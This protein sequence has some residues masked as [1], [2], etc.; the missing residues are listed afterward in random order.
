VPEPHPHPQ[1][2]PHPSVAV[3]ARAG[4]PALLYVLAAFGVVLGGWGSMVSVGTGLGLLQPRDSYVQSVKRARIE[5]YERF[6]GRFGSLLPAKEDMERYAERE[7]DANYGR[8][9]AALPLAAVGAILSCLLFAGC[10]RT[11]MGDP[12]GLSAWSLAAMV[13]LPYQLLAATLALVTAHDLAG[14]LP[15]PSP[16]VAFELKVEN[17][18][19]IVV[20]GLALL[21]YGA[22]FLYLRTSSVQACF[23]S[24][25]ERKPPSA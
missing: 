14:A 8:R 18:R 19:T 3:R 5:V 22:C 21:Y 15:N 1:P 17:L 4:T 12:W 13:S 7:A 6:G 10:T 2:P 23:T 11:I 9:D 16:F 20:A 25:A 24:G